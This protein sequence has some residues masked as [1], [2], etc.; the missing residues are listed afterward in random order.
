MN[1]NETLENVTLYL[2]VPASADGQ[3]APDLGAALVEAGEATDANFSYRVADTERGPMLAVTADRIA[4]TPRYYEYVERDGRGERT[5]IPES[6]YDPSNPDVGKDADAGT[7]LTVTVPAD[8]PVATADPWGVEPLFHPR[9]D[10]R[11]TACDSPAA[12]WLRCYEYDSAV[13]AAYDANDTA[14]VN[15]VT[16]VEGQNAWWVFGWN[17]DSYR[18]GVAVELRGP[19]DGWVNVTGT[20][21]V[22]AE[23]REP[24]RRDTSV[25]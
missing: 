24:P 10:R 5:R 21:E 2:P 25:S 14:R 15:V 22:D 8:A 13:Y 11:P 7:L 17:Y 4:V 23:P 1:T 12:D 9:S 16:R 3:G 19:Q 18:D 20:V 6:E